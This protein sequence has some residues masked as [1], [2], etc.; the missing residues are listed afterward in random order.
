MAKKLPVDLVEIAGRKGWPAPLAVIFSSSVCAGLAWAAR[1]V[2]DTAASDLPR[3]PSPPVRQALARTSCV[4]HHV[5]SHSSP[6]FLSTRGQ[7]AVGRGPCGLSDRQ[8]GLGAEPSQEC[9]SVCLTDPPPRWWS[10]TPL[11]RADWQTL[12]SG[13][14]LRCE[15]WGAP[16]PIVAC[17]SLSSAN[18]RQCVTS[19]RPI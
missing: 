3:S 12:R 5:P 8:P 14:F 19:K 15:G 16:L 7:A 9:L 18:P 2:K 6:S 4:S 13:G 1:P 10:T 11:G 17:S